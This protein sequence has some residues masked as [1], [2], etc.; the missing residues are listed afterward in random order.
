MTQVN[1]LSASAGSGKTFRLVLKYI[2]DVLKRP[3]SYLNILAVTFTNKAT[4]EIKSRIINE[5]NNLAENHKSDYLEEIMKRTGFSEE[6][7]RSQAVIARTQILHDY[8]RFTVLTID[9]FFQR[10]LRAFINELNLD[11]DYNIELDT[12]MLLERSADTLINSISESDKTELKNELI[13]FATNKLKEGHRWDMRRDLCALGGE[14]FKDGVAKRISSGDYRKSLAKIIEDYNEKTTPILDEIKTLG[15]KGVKILSNNNLNASHFRGTNPSFITCFEQYK[16]G[17]LGSG[18]NDAIRN[19][20]N[21]INKWYCIKA[22]DKVK[23]VA[24]ELQKI[25][26]EICDIYDKN[27]HNINTTKLLNKNY[28]SYA[29][30][31]DLHQSLKDVCKMENIMVLDKTKELLAE[32]IDEVNAP[33]IYEKVGNRYDHYMIDEFQDTS[34]REW[35]NLLPLLVEALSSNQDASVFIVG[36]IKQSIYRWRGGHWQLLKNGIAENLKQYNP[37]EEPLSINRRSLE[38]IVKFNN[39]FIRKIV[40]LD[41]A[42]INDQIDQEKEKGISLKTHQELENI[43]S[44]AYSNGE[45]QVHRLG[46][47]GFA[48]VTLFDPR[49]TTPPF[50]EAIKDA[51]NRGY[52]YKDILILVRFSSDGTKVAKALYE[53]KNEI[54]NYNKTVED[55]KDKKKVFNILTSDSLT[56]DSC[57]VV[58][59]II[60]LM[61]LAIDPNNDIERG[62]Y[63]NHLKR[64]H[65]TKFSNEELELFSEIAHLSALEAFELIVKHFNLYEEKKHVAY[66]QAIHEQIL[67]YSNKHIADIQHYLTWWDERGC[68]E[69]LSVEKT[70]DT[71][72]ITT[73]HKSKGLERDVVIIPYCKWG[74]TPNP[75]LN[76]IVWASAN[77]S[78]KNKDDAKILFPVSYSPTMKKSAFSEEYWKEFVMSHVDGINLLYVA[79]TRAKK[80]LYMYIPTDPKFKSTHVGSYTDIAGI[81]KSSIESLSKDVKKHEQVKNADNKVIYQRYTYGEP[82]K[83]HKPKM[84]EEKRD[85]FILDTYPTHAPRVNVHSQL[86]R[87]TREGSKPGSASCNRGIK[88]HKIFEGANTIDD[89]YKA[90]DHMANNGL[91]KDNE[92]KKLRVDIK[93]ALNNNLVNTWFSGEWEEVRCEQE[94]LR[95]GKTLRPDRVMISGDRAVVVDYKFAAEPNEDYHR[96][97]KDYISALQEMGCYTTL[98]G[99][100]WYVH[101]DKIECVK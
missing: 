46:K 26:A 28:R 14:L 53:Y 98:E 49:L 69:S 61:R 52:Q 19:A 90:I 55:D 79:V 51:I 86:E 72:E 76:S 73:I 5:L 77:K 16:N 82:I 40:E 87:F 71:I 66:L 31:N 45:Q 10:I 91:I 35:N 7:V 80:E 3:D 97:V 12:D 64:L 42:Y 29:L 38:N 101:L 50:I 23:R 75:T 11:L 15:A 30:L 6:K 21:D 63:N 99:Y 68:K 56:I 100:I 93:Q 48:E 20:V 33:F 13:D 4:E 17:I 85:C 25:L 54:I 67:S 22:D 47:Q 95:K 9:S 60:A 24:N 65:G 78:N 2:C 81:I 37:T 92:A 62:I 43:I 32:F 18:P 41:N 89:L 83:D 88:M 8:S 74:M 44:E 84:E 70:D 34:V 39:M 1:I 36:D 27:I 58:K 57:S 96:Q 94:I 59:F